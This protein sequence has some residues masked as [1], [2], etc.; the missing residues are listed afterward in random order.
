[1][2]LEDK[3]PTLEQS[4]RI[5]ELLGE[6]APESEHHYRMDYNDSWVITTTMFKPPY[7]Y[8]HYPAYD[9]AELGEMLQNVYEEY[10]VEAF[11]IW[12]HS[13]RKCYV[14]FNK[15]CGEEEVDRMYPNEAQARAALLI[16]LLE[17]NKEAS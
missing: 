7:K 1:M 4:K 15:Y 10:R 6:G 16:N 12:Y 8:E 2:K 13:S 11:P 3:F 5:A 9:L 14:L 17:T